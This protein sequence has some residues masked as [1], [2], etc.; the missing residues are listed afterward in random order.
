M[1]EYNKLLKGYFNEIK[2]FCK[3]DQEVKMATGELSFR[4]YLD[5]FL[6]GVATELDSTI[7]RIFE[8]RK[9]GSS[10]RPDWVFT[11]SINMGVYGY[12][13]AKELSPNAEI[14]IQ[15]VKSQISRY[16]NLGNP[17]LLTDG[18]EFIYFGISGEV[19]RFLLFDKPLDWE[20]PT[21]NLESIS[22]FQKFFSKVGFRSI[23]ESMIISELSKRAKS[24]CTELIELLKLNEDEAENE[25]EL[26]TIR[27]LKELWDTASKNLDVS[28]SDDKTFAGFVAQILAF[29]LLYAHRFINK[30][31]STPTQIY[32][33]LNFFWTQKPYVKY[34]KHVEPFVHLFNALSEELN[35]K[36]SKIGGW[37]DN[38][39]RLLSHVKLNQGVLS[40]PDFHKLYEDF[41][42]EYDAETRVDYGAWYTPTLLADY[43]VRL[44]DFHIQANPSFR[45]IAHNPFHVIDPC[46][47]TG[48]FNESVLDKLSLPAKSKVVG[49]EI[50]P[51]P[52][53]LANYRMSLY[54]I[55]NDVTVSIHLTNTLGDNTFYCPEYDLSKLDSVGLFFA[56]EQVA[57]FKMS[58]PPLTIIL[59]NPPCSDSSITNAGKCLERL[60]EDF[61]PD[62]RTTRQNTQMQLANEWVKFF[63][64]ALYKA[65]KS[66]P[67][68]IALVL[69]SVF[70]TNISF[71]YARRFLVENSSEIS[72]LE[73]DSD[74]RVG[75]GNQ[76]LFNTLQGR[77]LLLSSFADKAGSSFVRYKNICHLSRSEKC[78]YFSK[79]LKHL[80]WDE[81]P[82]DENYA[83]R[84]IGEYDKSLYDKFIP[85]DSTSE[86]KGVFLRHCS[87]LK[88]APTHLLVHFSKG[89]LTRR[90]KF[91]ADGNHTYNEIKDRW[92]SGQV[93]PPAESK[94]TT[95][96]CNILAHVK[97]QVSHYSYRPFLEAYV[98]DNID[99]LSALA[100]T[101]GG[102]MRYRP[103]VI[104][105]FSDPTVFGFSIAPAPAEISE[106]INKF[107]SFS[108]YL[109]DNDL[110]TRGNAHIYCN[111]F[112][113]YKKG[114]NWVSQPVNNVNPTLLEKLSEILD[115]EVEVIQDEI[116]YY[117]YAILS[118]PFFLNE[119]GPRLHCVAGQMPS[120]PVVKE[121]KLFDEV[122]VI[123][124]RLAHLERASYA[125]SPAESIRLS[126][127]DWKERMDSFELKDYTF[128]QN[129]IIFKTSK[130]EEIIYELPEP[131]K[132]FSISGYNILREWLKYHSYAYYR[133]QLSPEDIQDLISL[134]KRIRLY[135]DEYERLDDLIMEIL[136]SE[137]LTLD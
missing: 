1:V 63:R 27:T 85:L 39:R 118:S 45:A 70:A 82:I 83:F 102:G 71:K 113:E 20:H 86:S 64:W 12:I 133:K 115:R 90:S 98:I 92:Y 94:L 15:K 79:E 134:V 127:F 68:I 7:Q 24:L 4:P 96:V 46:C 30:E 32:D 60:M 50:L 110:C 132:D 16:L 81:L 99:L 95:N 43:M 107:C 72:I 131:I 97:G 137:L 125:F 11:D 91:I 33:C 42:A 14:D 136:S 37:Y 75:T 130:R 84:P 18:I 40:K 135:L 114:Q 78:D 22:L 104:A 128:T 54:N 101:K 105:A 88:L 77:L 108:W 89:Q 124:K 53:A 52:Y 112:L 117:S 41:L 57:S 67:S 123:G 31:A 35:S 47:G 3:F 26:R 106:K 21:Y 103:E 13:E 6:V 119:F 2:G 10:G 17:V 62:N 76:N 74:N 25:I 66:R 23:P 58:Q 100:Q 28:L 61:R 126:Q 49:F 87:G 19:E 34:S 51:V 29:G 80:D 116:V 38:T 48:T 9:Q 122:V 109:P 8:P 65:M 129:S 69:P 73:F 5:K 93:K 44:V 111:K 36:L 59:G 55:P 120:V 121:K 56:Q